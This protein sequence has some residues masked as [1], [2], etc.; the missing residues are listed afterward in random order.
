MPLRYAVYF[1][2]PAD[3]PLST[4]AMRWLGRDA[5]TGQTV[6]TFHGLDEHL[7]SP[8]KYGF[9]GTLKAPFQLV[10]GVRENE[11][12]ELFDNFAAEHNAFELPDMTLARLG[13]FFAL[14]PS[15]PSIALSQLAARA[16]KA[17]EPMRAPLSAADIARRNPD[18]LSP[19][20]RAHL[21]RWGYP[22]VMDE[23][24]FHMTLTDQIEDA[25]S[26][27]VEQAIRAHFSAF[28]DHPLSIATLAL[29]VERARGEPFTVLQIAAL[30]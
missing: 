1:T 15:E 9:H 30:S 28:I 11:L 25:D 21:A 29:F 10:A 7:V 22:Y 27:Q 26:E 23:F 19:N 3:D 20:Q 17:F 13:E 16:V 4:C 12:V 5:F 18:K 8:R 24:R 2:P 6:E 14:L